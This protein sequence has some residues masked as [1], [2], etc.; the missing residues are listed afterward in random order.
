MSL[1]KVA[2]ATALIRLAV[3]PVSA[4]TFGELEAWC[5][6]PEADGRP[7]LCTGYLETYLQGLTST[8]PSLNNGVRACVPEAEDRSVVVRLI[9]VYA[10]EHPEARTLPAIVGVG[11][12]LKDRYPCP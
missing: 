3:S 8:D 9:Q 6:P 11:E 10:R 1:S 2:L 4:A 12:A 7:A 5:A